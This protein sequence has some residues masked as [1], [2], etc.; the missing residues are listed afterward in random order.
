MPIQGQF[1]ILLTNL[2]T[3]FMPKSDAL[4]G[5]WQIKKVPTLFAGARANT[6]TVRRH[7]LLPAKSEDIRRLNALSG[8]RRERS[9]PLQIPNG[10]P[11]TELWTLD[12]SRLVQYCFMADSRLVGNTTEA[13][14]NLSSVV[15]ATHGIG[16][17]YE[18]KAAPKT[19]RPDKPSTA[20]RVCVRV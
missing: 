3:E 17:C 1:T 10:T 7:F 16:A 14:L 8:E 11:Y 20:G 2:R 4:G 19:K 6:K 18:N 13:E 5:R 9:P 15:G 12:W